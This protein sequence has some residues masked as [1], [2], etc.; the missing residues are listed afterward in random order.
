[1]IQ[2]MKELKKVYRENFNQLK[3]AKTQVFYIQ[4]SIDSLKQSLV[5]A[6]EDWYTQNFDEGDDML[7][8]LVRSLLISYKFSKK[9]INQLCN[10][11]LEVRQVPQLAKEWQCRPILQPRI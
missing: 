2:R 9:R 7:S 8:T 1:M 3:D 6:F 10:N 4:Q 11:L 5:G